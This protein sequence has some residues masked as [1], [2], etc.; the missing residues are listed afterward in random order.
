MKNMIIVA[1]TFDTKSAELNYIR[2][3]VV[4]AGCQAQTVDLS[5]SSGYKSA[6]DVTP[7]AVAAHHPDGAGSVFTNDRGS[8]VA[9]MAVAFEHYLLA[10][11]DIG[12]IIGAGGSGGTAL[13]SLGMRA[14]PVG[15]PKVLVSTVASGDVRPYVGPADICMMYSVTDVQGLNSI[16]RKVLANA[17]HAIAGMVSTPVP[18]AADSRPG[19][20]LTMFGVTTPCIQ[21]LSKELEKTYDCFVFHATGVG[22]QS[23]EKLVDSHMLKAVLDITTT[24]I[25][26]LHMGGVFSAGEERLDAI[27]RTGIPYVGSVG[28]LDMVNFGAMDTVPERYRDRKLYVHNP[29]VTLMRTTVEENGKMGAWIAEKLNRMTGPVRFLL[30]LRG[31]SLID[32]EGQPFFDPAADQALFQAIETNFNPTP[33]R[34]LIT[35]D[36]AINDPVFVEAALAAFNEINN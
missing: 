34:K 21:A 8:S 1:G 25:A 15:V 31:V 27:I 2:D 30:P 32:V 6:A 23:M 28:A 36:A 19:I 7:G 5:T 12:G 9:A 4:A 3:L 24:E 17:A 10:N 33:D 26:D 14:L 11:P 29:Q 22:G 35:V 16:S 18:P 13:V 20:G